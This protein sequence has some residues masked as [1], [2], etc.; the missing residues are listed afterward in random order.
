MGGIST[1][2][3]TVSSQ[4][5]ST[6]AH[7][8][9]IFTS[10]KALSNTVAQ[11]SDGRK[12]RLFPNVDQDIVQLCL[13]TSLRIQNSKQNILTQTDT[14]KARLKPRPQHL[15]TS[16]WPP[17]LSNLF[18][19]SQEVH[20]AKQRKTKPASSMPETVPNPSSA[21]ELAHELRMGSSAVPPRL[22]KTHEKNMVHKVWFKQLQNTSYTDMCLPVLLRH[23][24]FQLRN[25]SSKALMVGPELAPAGVHHVKIQLSSLQNFLAVKKTHM[26]TGHCEAF[27]ASAFPVQLQVPSSFLDPFHQITRQL[28]HFV[29]AQVS[30][31]CCQTMQQHGIVSIKPMPFG[32][33]IVVIGIVGSP[34]RRPV[35]AILGK[36][37]LKS[38]MDFC[39][40]S[41]WLFH[42]KAA[43]KCQAE[44]GQESHSGS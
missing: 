37:L 41:T 10:R 27:K 6:N 23:F 29:L 39:L 19:G 9:K 20:S 26:Q 35:N 43:K 25:V 8:L 17:H 36:K 34:N 32:R 13:A 31:S 15:P 24:N 3:T 1:C 11:R 12:T 38:R 2:H 5:S 44:G 40:R 4:M 21:E 28:D 42:Q 30:G 14:H 22:P 16:Q 18:P 33:A 7:C